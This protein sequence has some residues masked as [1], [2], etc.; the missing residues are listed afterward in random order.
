MKRLSYIL[1]LVSTFLF[2]SCSDELDTAPSDKVAA[3]DL[4]K[5][6]ESATAV[7]NGVY[8]MM[9]YSGWSANW[10]PEN[11][12]QVSVT[13][14]ANLM[15]DDHIMRSAGSGWYYYDYAFDTRMD[16]LG[17]S[18][19]Q[20]AF[21]NLYYT[22]I[23]NVNA[24]LHYEQ[25]LAGDEKQIKNLI[26]QA[27]AMRAFAYHQ[28]VQIYQHPVT[29]DPDAPGIPIY[30]EITDK[31]SEGK[32]RGTVKQ[33]YDQINLDIAKAITLFDEA[34]VARKHISHVNINVA[35]ALKARIDMSQDLWA[36][37]IDA[38][39]K[40]LSV[41][42]G[43]TFSVQSVDNYG[44]FNDAK[45]AGVLWGSEINADQTSGWAS[46]F[47]IMDADVEGT[48][49]ARAQHQISNWLYN[50]IPVN[51]ARKG[52]WNGVL[53]AETG[54]SNVNYGQKKYR[55]RVPATRQGDYLH[56]RAEEMVLTIAEAYCHLEN[57]VAARQEISKLGER[58][59][60][61]EDYQLRLDQFTDSK[62]YNTN[63]VDDLT[64]LMDE[65]LF[66]RRVELWGEGTGR[67]FDLQR[68]G[69]GISRAWTGNNHT[70]RLTTLDTSA[71]S[72]L[73]IQPL[74]QSEVDGN[75]NISVN[76]QNPI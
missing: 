5:D 29:A 30:T 34:R 19:R 66:Q 51:D 31:D 8:R 11:A 53:T 68:L 32:S 26:A 7:I 48:Y 39:R 14:V 45:S 60:A 69:L 40:A 16:Y 71:G 18:G 65:I 46:F 37:A 6:V 15:A 70:A 43:L 62:S 73:F 57:F 52:W 55:F 20:Y 4:F 21:W 49:A 22:M 24:I 63:T 28:L 42:G 75:P 54:G 59:M 61:A 23:S 9:Y 47:S 27:Y 67:L 74:P 72:K 76:D 35:Y 10:A 44:A 17:R 58:R 36:D 1:M 64:T 12:G 50:Q 13:L 41:E 3:V 56:I 33:V 2:A 25:D 38:A